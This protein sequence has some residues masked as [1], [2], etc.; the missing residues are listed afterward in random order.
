M[1]V[2]AVIAIACLIATSFA[3]TDEEVYDKLH[4]MENSKYGKTL[5]DTIQLQITSNGPVE[6]L[7]RML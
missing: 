4:K 2:L 1:K 5:L 7:I 6:D 3:T